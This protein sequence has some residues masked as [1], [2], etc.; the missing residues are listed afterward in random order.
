MSYVAWNVYNIALKKKKIFPGFRGS[1]A[2][3][4]KTELTIL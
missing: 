3:T 2:A 4:Q 1:G